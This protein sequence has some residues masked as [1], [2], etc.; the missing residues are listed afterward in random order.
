[1]ATYGD[2]ET[3]VAAAE[4][5]VQ[6]ILK[7][8]VSPVVEDIVKQHIQTDIYDV[9][10]PKAGA[11]LGGTYKRRHALEENIITLFPTP[12]ISITTSTATASP[13]VV[14]GYSFRNRY[15]G[16]FLKLLESGNMG[17]WKNGFPRPVISN[18]QKNVDKSLKSGA[19]ASAIKNGI[20]REFN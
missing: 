5:K 14:K 10:T 12:S 15:P 17:I 4:K 8:D 7:Q 11:W 16:A 18:A 6:R 13:S 2:W 19:I 1:M 3:L 20:K 9:Y